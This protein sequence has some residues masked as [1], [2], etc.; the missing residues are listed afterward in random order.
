MYREREYKRNDA[1]IAKVIMAHSATGSERD[2]SNSKEQPL[3]L[4]RSDLISTLSLSDTE[5]G[6]HYLLLF[7]LIDLFFQIKCFNILNKHNTFDL[8]LR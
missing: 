4:S 1:A 5:N 8:N 7:Y 3:N 6:T 2:L